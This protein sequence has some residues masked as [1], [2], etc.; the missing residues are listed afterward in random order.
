MDLCTAQSLL[1][2]CMTGHYNFY[3]VCMHVYGSVM[4]DILSDLHKKPHLY[5]SRCRQKVCCV[6][7]ECLFTHNMPGSG[8]DQLDI[9][10]FA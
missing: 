7:A 5:M 1:F 10:H 9:R 4:S 8:D 3:Y 2:L 6:C